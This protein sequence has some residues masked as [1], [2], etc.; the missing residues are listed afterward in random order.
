MILVGSQFPPGGGCACANVRQLAGYS[1]RGGGGWR[2]GLVLAWRRRCRGRHSTRG[3]GWGRR[4]GGPPCAGDAHWRSTRRR[5]R[6][7]RRRPPS[8]D[9]PQRVQQSLSLLSRG[10]EQQDGAATVARL[11]THCIRVADRAGAVAK[12]A[13]QEQS[14]ADRLLRVA[15]RLRRERA[16]FGRKEEPGRHRQRLAAVTAGHMHGRVGRASRRHG[17]HVE[18][19]AARTAPH[20]LRVLRVGHA[21]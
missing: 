17:A 13:H 6:R 1:R 14:G 21:A 10:W 19:R 3:A 20:V 2:G 11:E 4:A 18:H 7:R 12:G 15:A 8:S 5:L 9:C 16:H